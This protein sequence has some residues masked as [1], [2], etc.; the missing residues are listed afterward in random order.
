MDQVRDILAVKGATVHTIEKNVTVF[1]AIR[2]MVDN[3][4][5]SLSSVADIDRDGRPDIVAGFTVYDVETDER[6]EI[7]GLTVKWEAQTAQGG[8]VVGDGFQGV[9]NFDADDRAEVVVVSSGHVWL[10]DHDGTVLWGPVIIPGGGAGG[11]PTVADFDGDGEPEIGVAGAWRY[12]VFETDG[13]WKWQAET[14]RSD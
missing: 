13:T 2:K 4:V 9:G 6:N 10:L 1:D 12:V 11:P 8:Q 5:G 7:T 14:G 3:G